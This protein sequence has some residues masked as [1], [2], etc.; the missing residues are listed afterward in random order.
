MSCLRGS[1]TWSW[2]RAIPA[3]MTRASRRD[4][5]AVEPRAARPGNA[6][7]NRAFRREFR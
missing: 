3:E 7:K 1:V 6:L 5:A 4:R 2:F